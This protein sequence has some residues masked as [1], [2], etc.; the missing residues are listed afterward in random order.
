MHEVMCCLD[1]QGGILVVI[2]PCFQVAMSWEGAQVGFDDISNSS[3][4]IQCKCFLD[5]GSR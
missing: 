4:A 2:T 3:V 5:L 1:S